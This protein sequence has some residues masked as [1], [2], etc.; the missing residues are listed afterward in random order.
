MKS[1]LVFCLLPQKS[2]S[3]DVATFCIRRAGASFLAYTGPAYLHWYMFRNEM[4]PLAKSR[5]F[6]IFMIGIVG[7]V[8]GTTVTLMEMFRADDG[9]GG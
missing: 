9:G 7:S 5:D 4:G 6:F 1:F 8:V 2:S 3:P